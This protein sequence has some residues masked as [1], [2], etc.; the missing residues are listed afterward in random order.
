MNLLQHE[1]ACISDIKEVLGIAK[2]Q[3]GGQNHFCFLSNSLLLHM[4]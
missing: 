2:G 3:E 4:Y 1:I